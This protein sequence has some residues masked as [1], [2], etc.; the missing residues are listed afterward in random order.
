MPK[1]SAVRI[2]A[3]KRKLCDLWGRI[4][5]KPIS[6][7]EIF[8]EL[9]Y[10]YSKVNDRERIYRYNSQL[11]KEA[12]VEW[13]KFVIQNGDKEVIYKKWLD[14]CYLNKIPYILFDSG[15]AISPKTYKEWQKILEKICIR[16]LF[17]LESSMRRMINKDMEIRGLP[18][19][20]LLPSYTKFLKLIPDKEE[21]D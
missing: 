3:V 21:E 11:Q 8:K 18:L 5:I 10:D 13:D 20:I 16:Q 1:K 14:Y 2:E 12:E 19:K 15:F 4:L 7:E 9:G 6:T 17:G